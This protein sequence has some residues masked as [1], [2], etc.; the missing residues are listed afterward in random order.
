[1]LAKSPDESKDQS[2]FLWTLN[3]EDLAHTIFPIGHLKKTQVR[4]LADKY[5]LP[6][7]TKKDSQGVCFLGPLDMKDFLKHYIK[8][9]KGEVLDE[10]GN[11]IGFHDGAVF[12]T[13]GERHGFTITKHSVNDKPMYVVA[14]DVKKN[15]VTVSPKAPLLVEE[16]AGGGVSKELPPPRPSGTPPQ[17]GG[18]VKLKNTNLGILPRTVLGAKAQ[19]R[20]HGELLACDVE[21]TGGDTANIIFKSTVLVSPGQ[22]IV[23]YDGDICLGGGVV[24]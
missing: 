4:K 1:R 18:E 11:A 10:S 6:T 7:A 21:I 14:K 8:E 17:A 15:T 2:Y 5:K 9:V 23:V 24:I 19:I 16:G 22:S 13:L 3:Q 20:Y 12:L